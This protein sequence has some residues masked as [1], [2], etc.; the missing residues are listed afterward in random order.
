MDVQDLADDEP[1]RQVPPSDEA[2]ARRI[3][4]ARNPDQASRVIS[5]MGVNVTCDHRAAVPCQANFAA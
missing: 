1:A 3:A 2:S 5:P 4:F